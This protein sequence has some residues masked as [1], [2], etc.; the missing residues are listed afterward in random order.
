MLN[1]GAVRN[2][3]NYAPIVFLI[4]LI[5]GAPSLRNVQANYHLQGK[6]LDAG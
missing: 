5:K 6:Y 1:L 3:L 2:A 4:G